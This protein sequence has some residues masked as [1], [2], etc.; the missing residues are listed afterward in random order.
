MASRV[1]ISMSPVSR[2]DRIVYADACHTVR[3]EPDRLFAFGACVFGVQC[4]ASGAGD[5]RAVSVAAGGYRSWP[6]SPGIRRSD[7]GGS[8]LA[9]FGL[10]LSGAHAVGTSGGLPGGIER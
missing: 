6:L 2:G 3:T 7:T 9:R 8:V 5:R 4:V 10:G 1:G